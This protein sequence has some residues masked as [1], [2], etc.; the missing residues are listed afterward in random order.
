V[1]ALALAE[2]HVVLEKFT[3]EKVNDIRINQLMAKIDTELVRKLKLGAN[4][5]V[6]M[7]NGEE[8]KG[9]MKNPKGT[10]A[11]PLSF[12]EIATKFKNTAKFGVV[13]KDLERLIE[14]IKNFETLTDIEEI[15]GLTTID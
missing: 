10:P 9:V 2:G 13:E 14:K 3:D 7:K 15:T 4:V 6:K 5:I 8:Y 11:N 1:A 12:D